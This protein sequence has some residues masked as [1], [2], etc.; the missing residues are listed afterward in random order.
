M[1]SFLDGRFTV[2][3]WA[4]LYTFTSRYTFPETKPVMF[5]IHVWS[6]DNGASPGDQFHNAV[7]TVTDMAGT[8]TI[9]NDWVGNGLW[10]RHHADSV[11]ESW[12]LRWTRRKV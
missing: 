9:I 10:K 1:A 4:G 5:E 7:M 3:K 2:Y 6:D 8:R 12:V 11:A